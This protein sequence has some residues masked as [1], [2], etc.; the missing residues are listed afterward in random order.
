MLQNLWANPA[1]G[2]DPSML[3][4]TADQLQKAFDTFYED[5]FCELA[6]FGKI[7]EMH[8]VDNVGDHLIGNTYIRYDFEDE[9]Q[10]AV[11]GLSNRWYAGRPLFCELSPVT[12]FREACASSLCAI[13][14]DKRRLPAT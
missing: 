4:L 3:N 12:D 6:K 10:A 8:V 2:H 7:M 9:A 11:D 1:H 13:R 5:I 14:A